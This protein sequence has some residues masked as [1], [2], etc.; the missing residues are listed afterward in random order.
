MIFKNLC[1]LHI[2]FYESKNW[3]D[4]IC[5]SYCWSYHFVIFRVLTVWQERNSP[6]SLLCTF[7]RK[8]VMIFRHSS[9]SANVHFLLRLVHTS[10]VWR[11]V[12]G[13]F[14]TTLLRSRIIKKFSISTNRERNQHLTV[15]LTLMVKTSQPSESILQM[16]KCTGRKWH[17]ILE[18]FV[19]INY[20]SQCMCVDFLCKLWTFI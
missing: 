6:S 17:L 14:E 3:K 4:L 5:I 15:M 1:I 11:L 18:N 20:Y 7:T 10:P 2:T 16:D 12:R 8:M 19:V 9:K 13:Q